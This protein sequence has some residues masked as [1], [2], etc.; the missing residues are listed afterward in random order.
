MERFLTKIS[1][2]KSQRVWKKKGE[3]NGSIKKREHNYCFILFNFNSA[4]FND[5]FNT[6]SKKG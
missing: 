6:A 2:H 3:E 1:K 4:A 5:T